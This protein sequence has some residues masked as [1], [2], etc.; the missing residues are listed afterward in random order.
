MNA[1]NIILFVVLF[2]VVILSAVIIR[3]IFSIPVIV[4]NLKSQTN[5]LRLIAKKQG[6]TDK[7]IR[8]EIVEPVSIDLG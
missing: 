5:L 1:D 2:L 6:A 8:D 3:L 4:R 7:E